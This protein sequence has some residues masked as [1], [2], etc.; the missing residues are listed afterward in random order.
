MN[1]I[2]KTSLK[3]FGVLLLALLCAGKVEAQDIQPYGFAG[4]NQA[5]YLTSPSGILVSL[6]DNS[7]PGSIYCTYRWD[8]IEQPEGSSFDFP[9]DKRFLSNPRVILEKAGRYI[10]QLAR[11]SKYGIQREL[12]TVDLCTNVTLVSAVAKNNCYHPGELVRIEDFDI[13]TY[14][15]GFEDRVSIHPDDGVVKP[16]DPNDLIGIE[17][18]TVRFKMADEDGSLVDC[19]V[20]EKINVLESDYSSTFT[21]TMED[22]EA[23]LAELARLSSFIEDNQGITEDLKPYADFIKKIADITGFSEDFDSAESMIQFAQDHGND[24]GVAVGT[25]ANMLKLALLGKA[26]VKGPGGLNILLYIDTKHL[27]IGFGVDCCETK[28]RP[29]LMPVLMGK[30]T[31]EAGFTFDIGIPY[32]SFPGFG[33]LYVRGGLGFGIETPNY[34][35]QYVDFNC[36]DHLL[37]L[38]P[39]I[40]GT[41]ALDAI[42]RHPNLFSIEFGVYPTLYGK[43]FLG[44]VASN[45]YFPIKYGDYGIQL[46]DIRVKMDFQVRSTFVTFKSRSSMYEF[47]DFSIVK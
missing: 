33:G 5:L 35:L 41:I 22:K 3:A 23:L 6:G 25:A 38:H 37:E 30:A 20:V 36:S 42:L 34:W 14:P 16:L 10:F 19:N 1:R 46:K 31:V 32:L 40:V 28:Q 18:H 13:K 26:I 12:V 7:S 24:L 47:F 2:N 27:N 15:E 11:A 9:L 45:A 8:V 44:N 29:T 43:V 39:Y 21:V 17:Q 4:E